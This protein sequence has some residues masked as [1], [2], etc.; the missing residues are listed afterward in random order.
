MPS[1]SSAPHD[2]TAE[3]FL[4]AWG[5]P[6]SPFDRWVKG[7]AEVL[8]GSSQTRTPLSII[9]AA[10]LAS[11][12]PAEVA[13]VVKLSSLEDESLELLSRSVP[14]NTTWHE[15]AQSTPEAIVEALK[16]A[17]AIQ[18]W[19]GVGEAI[20]RTLRES[21]NGGP[22]E[23]IGGLRWEVLEAAHRRACAYGMF[24]E[25]DR[26]FM[27][28][29]YRFVRRYHRRPTLPQLTYLESLLQQMYDAGALTNRPGESDEQACSEILAALH[30]G[31]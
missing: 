19:K 17:S 11:T 7:V 23:R 3:R 12:T 29:M 1:R 22:L 18:D 5:A 27:R 10:L 31:R 24:R 15:I 9:D 6:R 26:N 21:T 2:T 20:L 30:G 8:Q 13:A 4:A 16:A 14:P 25:K 28:S